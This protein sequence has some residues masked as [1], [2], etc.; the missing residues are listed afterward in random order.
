MNNRQVGVRRSPVKRQSKAW[1]RESTG[2]L[3]VDKDFDEYVHRVTSI[4]LL[5]LCDESHWG[6]VCTWGL[7]PT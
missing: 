7:I 1:V 3:S 6:V 2:N 5:Q 4:Y